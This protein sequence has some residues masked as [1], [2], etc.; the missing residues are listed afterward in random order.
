M[1]SYQ[2]Y[3]TEVARNTATANNMLLKEQYREYHGW[4]CFIGFYV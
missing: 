3:P 2:K 1:G 4:C